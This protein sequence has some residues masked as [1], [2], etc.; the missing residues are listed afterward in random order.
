MT[1]AHLCLLATVAVSA[2]VPTP[3]APID[4]RTA[5]AKVVRFGLATGQSAVCP[6]SAVRVEAQLEAVLEGDTDA[7]TVFQHRREIDDRIFDLAQLHLSSPHGTFDRDG[8]F[9]ASPDV[10]AT[11]QTGFV[12]NVRAPRGPSFAVRYPP[13]YECTKTIGGEGA[14]GG[15][16]DPGEDAILGESE[17]HFSL[18][19][20]GLA[21]GGRPGHPGG[22]GAAGPK[23]TV[24]VTWVR[25]PDYTR[26]L[27]AKAVGDVDGFTLVAPGTTLEVVARGGR[28]GHGGRGGRGAAAFS[29][30]EPSGPG[31]AG[32]VGGTGGDGG[33]VELV[34]DERWEDLSR[35]V[36]VDIDGGA[37]GEGGV[38]G[39]GGEAGRE[40]HLTKKGRPSSTTPYDYGPPGPPGLHGGTGNHGRAGSY[41]SVR[42]DVSKA[43]EGLGPVVPL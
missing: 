24:Y 27:A 40:V 26:L 14:P 33:D 13:S 36:R 16:G 2:C 11:A 37:A 28:G 18:G 41:R 10:L 35:W 15:D 22:T 38:G 31:G 32:G 5:D 29:I 6:G 25:S 20:D 34:L 43:F 1:R 17:G 21:G 12:L 19:G 3:R 9:H 7:V 8:I 30:Y 42:A 39:Q 23:V 4:L